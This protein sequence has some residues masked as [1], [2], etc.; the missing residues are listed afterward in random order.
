[1]ENTGLSP[2]ENKPPF[3]LIIGRPGSVRAGLFIDALKLSGNTSFEVLDYADLMPQMSFPARLIRPETVIRLDAPGQNFPFYK[4]LLSLGFE[5]TPKN[6]HRI[7]P[8]HA[9]RLAED[10]GRLLYPYQWFEGYRRFLSILQENTEADFLRI[11]GGSP[12][13][14]N[15]PEE[16]LIQFHKPSCQRL[17]RE[18]SLPVPQ[19]LG[20]FS[21][22]EELREK[23]KSA[24]LRQVFLKLP[25]SSSGSGIAAFSLENTGETLITPVE[26]HRKRGEIRFYDSRKI[27]TYQ[28]TDAVETI[29]QWYAKEGVHAEEWIDKIH[30]RGES[31]DLRILTV[32]GEIV[33]TMIRTSASPFTNLH[34]GGRRFTADEFSEKLPRD[35]IETVCRQAHALFPRTLYTGI[36]IGINRE[37]K[38]FIFE[39]NA[40]GDHLNDAGPDQLSHY[41]AQIR[42]M[43]ASAHIFRDGGVHV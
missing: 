4:K 1:M 29:L 5:T 42:S 18:N 14:M 35:R 11:T 28:E 33:K 20:T 27:R 38:P 21:H 24:G 8:V 31:M 6:F 43:T 7:P 41:Q 30:Y 22:P 13:W 32:Q 26:L 23:M 34:L 9:A 25:A 37:N 3:F 10:R 36:D 39:M 40:F 12:R 16:V 2:L 15:H 19:I 17:L